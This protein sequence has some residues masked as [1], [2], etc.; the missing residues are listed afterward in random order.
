M[1]TTGAPAA[2]TRHDVARTLAPLITMS[3][4]YVVRKAMISGYE[5]ATG[6]EAPKVYSHASSIG[7]RVFWTAAT[8]AMVALI[9]ALVFDWLEDE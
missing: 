4:T 3:A 7:S 2:R 6:K 8:A 5:R 1:S 9:E